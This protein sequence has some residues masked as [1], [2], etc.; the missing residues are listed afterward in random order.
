MSAYYDSINI[1]Q[2]TDWAKYS[3]NMYL[4]KGL[5]SRICKNAL[6]IQWYEDIQPIY[7]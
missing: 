2:A 5:L 1:R 3:K 7:K 6:T 4:T